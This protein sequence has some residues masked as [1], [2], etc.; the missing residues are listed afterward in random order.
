M[1]PAAHLILHASSVLPE[2]TIP[3]TADHSA[4]LLLRQKLVPSAAQKYW[5]LGSAGPEILISG[6]PYTFGRNNFQSNLSFYFKTDSNEPSQSFSFSQFMLYNGLSYFPSLIFVCSSAYASH[7]YYINTTKRYRHFHFLKW[8]L[9]YK[10]MDRAI[11]HLLRRQ[12]NQ[13]WC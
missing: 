13:A 11:E 2:Y 1:D 5:F 7:Q 3:L 10:G 9:K 6:Q 4:G 8:A 12:G